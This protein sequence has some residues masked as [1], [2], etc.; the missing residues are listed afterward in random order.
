MLRCCELCLRCT[1][2]RNRRCCQGPSSQFTV[3]PVRV[4]DCSVQYSVQSADSS[5]PTRDSPPV[6]PSGVQ[7]VGDDM[8][9]VGGRAA[10]SASTVCRA[11]TRACRL[12]AGARRT[13]Q[14]LHQVM[15]R[16][17]RQC[18]RTTVH[19][20]GRCRLPCVT[21]GSPSPRTVS[22]RETST[23]TGR[24]GASGRSNQRYYVV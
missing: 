22:C 11:G 15:Y 1:Y 20:T 6:S 8:H 2:V 7:P 19:R 16:L 23:K 18:S 5:S 10:G 4:V 13:R 21:S 14:P 3:T 17:Q 12:G 9:D 24:S